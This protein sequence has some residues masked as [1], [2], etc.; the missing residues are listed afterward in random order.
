MLEEQEAR[1][2]V[3]TAQLAQAEAAEEAARVAEEACR[4]AE[5]QAILDVAEKAERR[6]TEKAARKA[7]RRAEKQRK[8][9]EE[10]MRGMGAVAGSSKRVETEGLEETEEGADEAC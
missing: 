5:A 8:E 2:R 7:W 1:A 6:A 4:R 3:M 9:E 10:L